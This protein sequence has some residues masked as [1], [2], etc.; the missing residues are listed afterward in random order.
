MNLKSW[1]FRRKRWNVLNPRKAKGAFFNNKNL[2]MSTWSGGGEGGG[3]DHPPSMTAFIYK[4]FDP[5]LSYIKRQNNPK[6]GNLSRNFHIY[7]AAFLLSSAILSILFCSWKFHFLLRLGPPE[8]NFGFLDNLFWISGQ[9]LGFL[10]ENVWISGWICVEFLTIL[11]S[12]AWVKRPERQKGAMDG[13]KQVK[14]TDNLESGPNRPPDF[15]LRIMFDQSH[16]QNIHSQSQVKRFIIFFPD[17]WGYSFFSSCLGVDPWCLCVFVCCLFGG[18]FD[19][20]CGNG[21]IQFTPGG[22]DR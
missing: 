20:W 19:I 4:N 21:L 8:K 6:Y 1:I 2:C 9:F 12:I 11:W 15:Y 5:F 17:I 13:V 18:C 16:Y 14:R 7:L 3:G 22:R 10:G